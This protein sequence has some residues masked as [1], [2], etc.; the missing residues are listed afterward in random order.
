MSAFLK[1]MVLAVVQGLTEFL[2]V[3]SSGHL[4]LAKHLLGLESPGVVL[5]VGLHAGT[6]ISVLIYYRS[7]I[8]Q[9]VR[10]VVKG[11][12]DSRYYLIA[13]VVSSLPCGVVYFLLRERIE[14][15]FDAPVTVA[16]MLCITGLFL[17]SLM[18]SPV[19]NRTLSIGKGFWIG[20]VQAFAMVPGISRSGATIT[21]GRHLGLS[22]KMA[23]EFSLLMSVPVLL[24]ASVIK[25]V[26]MS[27]VEHGEVTVASMAAGIPVSACVGYVSIVCLVNTLSSGK[28]WLFGFYCLAVGVAGIVVLR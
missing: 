18:L 14:L 17:C 1:V 10:Q 19:S 12:G 3:S 4:V 23:V 7:R 2:P 9:L 11:E 21:L 25:L 26:S 15:L 16:V 8:F 24:A 20:V 22:P 28:L 27:G 13:I 6:L 5:E